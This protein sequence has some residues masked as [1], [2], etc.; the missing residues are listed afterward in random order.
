VSWHFNTR[1]VHAELAD[2]DLERGAREE[3]G[4]EGDGGV[5]GVDVVEAVAH[6]LEEAREVAHQPHR[7]A[8]LFIRRSL[9]VFVGLG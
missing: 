4:E 8:N 9:V 6:V 5:H 7:R 3:E 2:E 1:N